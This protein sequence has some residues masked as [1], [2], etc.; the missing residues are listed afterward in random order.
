MNSGAR[1][2]GRAI[3]FD[4]FGTVVHFAARVPVA[5]AAGAPWRAAMQWLRQA[6]EE[7]V[8]QL[9]F[10]DLLTALMRVTEEIV[11]QRPPEYREV[12]SHERFRRALSQLGVDTD[13]VRAAAERLSL[14]HMAHLAS[15]TI[16]PEGHL[17]LLWKLGARYPLGLVSN[18]DHG[19]TARRVLDAHGL[20]SR[21]QTIVISDDFGRRKPHRS[22][23]EAALQDLG[24]SAEETL[25]IGDSLGDDVCGARNAHLRVA[26]LNPNREPAPADGV[27][28]DY[29]IGCL[30]DLNALVA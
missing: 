13:G 11:R 16:L 4:L 24:A 15:L 2:R 30:A 9:G 22:I 1:W 3:L 18:F 12:P 14:A 19:P 23:F 29:V 20:S 25:F 6:A 17:R 26:W 27:Q 5:Q 8:P 21:F 28:P 7:E 10:E